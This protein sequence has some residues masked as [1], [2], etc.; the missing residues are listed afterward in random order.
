[1]KRRR[2]GGGGAEAEAEAAPGHNAPR[3]ESNA[4]VLQVQYSTESKVET[5][6]TLFEMYFFK[7]LLK[8]IL[9]SPKLKLDFEALGE[10]NTF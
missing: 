3:Y 9:V 8:F 10:L 5:H 7:L 4:V 2:G 6:R 1:M